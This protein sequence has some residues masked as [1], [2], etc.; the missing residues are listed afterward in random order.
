[1]FV[2]GFFIGGII[3]VGVELIYSAKLEKEEV[4]HRNYSLVSSQ[5]KFSREGNP[6]FLSGSKTRDVMYYNFYYN[7]AE[8]IKL[9]RIRANQNNIY[10]KESNVEKPSY[11]I[12]KMYYKDRDYN[13]GHSL[14]T[15]KEVLVVPK[16]SF[17]TS[18]EYDLN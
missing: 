18:H 8:G 14:Y 1:L 13:G 17:V 9:G 6:V 3:G 12:Y 2:G 11:K 7:T 15:T 4:V 5:D 10:I 16:G